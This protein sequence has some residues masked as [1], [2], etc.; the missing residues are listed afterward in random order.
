MKHPDT[1][2]HFLPKNKLVKKA[3]MNTLLCLIKTLRKPPLSLSET[4]LSNAYSEL[5]KLTEVGFKLDWLKSKLEKAS[6]ERKKSVSDGSQVQQL[7]EQVKNLELT[8]WDLKVE[9]EKEKIVA[10]KVFSFEFIDF[11]IKRF[12]L[13]CFSISKH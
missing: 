2:V 3:H 8:V 12:F 7:K 6:L 1:A 5:T 13:S 9:L 10:D 11:F 4:E